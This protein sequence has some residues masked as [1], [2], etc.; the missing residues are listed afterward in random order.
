MNY[1][2][3]GIIALIIHLVI[4]NDVMRRNNERDFIPAYRYYRAFLFSVTGYFITDILWGFLY[5]HE[6]A[7]LTV[8]DT[9]L[10]F[11]AMAC[12]ILF[13]TRFVIAYLN[14]ED[15]FSKF[16][17]VTG[18]LIFAAETIMALA[19]FFH[20]V[21]FSF[22]QQGV[23]H[24]EKGRFIILIAQIG[25]FLV[26]AV[27]AMTA[28]AKSDGKVK[29][30]YRAIWLS[31]LA[32]AGFII[33]QAYFPLL[34]MY[35][36]GC[37]LCSCVL[38]SYVLEDVKEEYRSELEV[39]LQESIHKGNY[40]DLLT[41][42]PSMTYFF[43]L[44][45]SGKGEV[46]KKGGKPVF[47]Y[48]DFTGMKFFNN[49]YGF[50]EGDK[51]LKSFA[52]I[53]IRVFGEGHCC[54]IGGDQFAV[55]T[56]ED[57]MEEKLDRVFSECRSLNNGRSLPIHVGIYT[58][59]FEEVSAGI[60]CDRA[61]M[62]CNELRGVYISCFHYYNQGL[63][64]DAEKTHY[65][66]E[67]IDRAIAEGWIKVYYQPIVRAITRKACE[68][69]ALARWIDPVKGFLSPADFIQA[70]EESGQI[71]K[72]DL[73]MLEQVLAK[74]QYQ[75]TA[76]LTTIPN[77]INLS[78][79][80]FEACDIVEEIRER[81][82][83]A[84][85]SHDKITIE[86]TESIIGSDPEF[87][88]EQITRFRSL[89]FPVWMDDFGSGY[90]SLDVLQSLKFDMVK[91]DMGFMRRLD[92][93]ENGRI[94]LTELM[95]MATS[96]GLS[97]VCEGVETEEQANF[98][99]EIGCSRLQGYLFSK[100]QP[101]EII[102]KKFGQ[103]LQTVYE[104][105]EETSYYD[106]IGSVNLY[107]LSS[108]VSK[109]D[110]GF[111]N[112]FNTLPMC[113][114]EVKDDTAQYVRSNKA[115]RDFMKRY[116]DFKIS[117]STV[118]P[119]SSK[120]YGSN[121]IRA[122]RQCSLDKNRTFFDEKLPDGS[123]AHC[124]IRRIGRNAVSGKTASAIAVLSITEPDEGAS[125][126]DIA[127]ALAADYYNIYVVDL[128]TENFI[129]Y[130]SPVG[131][132][133][134][135]MERHGTNFFESAKQDTKTRIYEEDREPFLSVFSKENVIRELD[136]QGVFTATYRLIDTGKP[137]YV[138]MK[139]TRM[140]PGGNRIILGVSIIEAQMKQKELLK[141]KQR[142]S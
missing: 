110:N 9:V 118:F 134:L 41:G 81:V 108:I 97:T 45:D 63:G 27:Y 28:S 53:L 59:W 91:F 111:Q 32:M 23:Y 54:R 84:G 44:A 78:R 66:A 100:P 73:Y 16:L 121:F 142:K 61:K 114:M 96:L 7:A 72:L 101:F 77:S 52:G 133:E 18:W 79:S 122:V 57:G 103:G 85:I 71:Y 58:D 74:M 104:N 25:M 31:S 1:S 82:D 132:D 69:E 24:A 119:E 39:K 12:S 21:M 86:I 92:E 55:I 34:P 56:L 19:S 80:D 113:I 4:N 36:V 120:L 6:L 3:T 140:Q 127:R 43:D 115:Y 26:T 117:G 11:L 126:A 67:N 49:K 47:L 87:M 75:K 70:L 42:L 141:E 116:F 131:R 94:L 139:V 95:Q 5:E 30:R 83:A 128:D 64:E 62:A 123:M 46:I 48:M 17:S 8:T 60:A 2:S 65:I 129:E 136:E 29:R 106:A 14:K 135:A 138:N 89:G 124:F 125:Y 38:H 15:F 90:S 22:D 102:P 105:P 98:L 68:E 20:P 51:L 50:A 99:Q 13:W 37:L 10:Y 76:G 130:T 88:K 40:F 93:D 33:A 112:F 137:M 35:A 107:D 109:D